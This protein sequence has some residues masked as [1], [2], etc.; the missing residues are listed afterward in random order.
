MREWGPQ[1]IRMMAMNNSDA[2]SQLVVAGDL[3]I[4]SMADLKGKRVA[5]VKG[6][7]SLNLNAY[8]MLRFGGLTWDDVKK[9]EF[10]GYGASFD[11]LSDGQVDAVYTLSTA[12]N[13]YKVFSTPRGGAWAP[14]PHADA[15]AWERLQKVAP[16]F[17][18][19]TCRE[20]GGVTQPFESGN[21]PYPVLIAYAK[22]NADM[23]HAMTKAMFDLYPDYKDSAPS[24]AGWGL[25]RQQFEWVVPFHEGAIRYYKEIGKWT[26]AAQANQDKLLARQQVIVKAWNAYLKQAPSDEAAFSKGWQKAR[27]DALTAAKEDVVFHEW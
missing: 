27:A 20:G 23:V 3:G 14:L 15:A 16:Y 17:Y 10:G 9:V 21:Y 22:Q 12:G 25:D 6:A 1:D 5:W 11:G 7:P 2:C 18:K 19:T 24:A 4:K 26:A 13:V 8:A